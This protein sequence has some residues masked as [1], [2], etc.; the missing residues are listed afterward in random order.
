M[1]TAMQRFCLAL[2][3]RGSHRI[4]AGVLKFACV[5]VLSAAIDFGVLNALLWTAP[6]GGW[7]RTLYNSV[8]VVCALANSY[9]WNCRWTFAERA[10]GSRSER[11]RFFLQAVLNVALNDAT[12]LT[13]GGWLS[14]LGHLQPRVADDAAKAA[15][16]LISSTASYELMRRWVF[17]RDPAAGTPPSPSCESR[18]AR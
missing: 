5:G 3:I 16:M 2:G 6:A 18:H 12:W 15:A 1:P 17:R 11:R 7:L 14:H 13:L 9:A 8:A 4:R 10:D